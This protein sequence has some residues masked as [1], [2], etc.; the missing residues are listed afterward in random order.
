MGFPLPPVCALFLLL[1]VSACGSCY[2]SPIDE[3]ALLVPVVK[4]LFSFI[5]LDGAENSLCISLFLQ[6]ENPFRD[7]F[8]QH[9]QHPS[10]RFLCCFASP[11]SPCLN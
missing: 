5:V 6:S 10:S 8:L 9:F 7:T 3:E 4:L 11:A 1:L 2:V